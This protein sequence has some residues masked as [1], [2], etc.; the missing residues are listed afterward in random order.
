MADGGGDP[1]GESNIGKVD[2]AEDVG[3][4]KNQLLARA[5][6]NKQLQGD[7]QFDVVLIDHP[8]QMKV[9]VQLKQG[10]AWEKYHQLSSSKQV[11]ELAAKHTFKEHP[12][13]NIKV[14][15]IP[16]MNPTLNN[17]ATDTQGKDPQR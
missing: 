13:N 10:E 7:N 12:N 9:M 5:E 11:A 2:K 8:S 1:P 6:V 14:Y 17:P 3:L 15:P 16:A 4:K